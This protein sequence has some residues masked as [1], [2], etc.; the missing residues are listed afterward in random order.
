[1][2]IES[3]APLAVLVLGWAFVSGA[4]QRQEITGPFV[5]V[6]AGALLANDAWGPFPIAVE[7]ASVH[8][9]AE[10]ALA[11]VLFSDAVRID[12]RGLRRHAALPARLLLVG[13]PV[14]MALG[15]GAAL[16]LLSDLPWE[17]ALLVAAA[18]APT[19]AALS[20]QVVGDKRVPGRLRVALNVES[21]LN[22]GMAT[23]V[24]ALAIALAA[25]VLGLGTVERAGIGGALLELGLGLAVGGGFG[26]IGAWGVTVSSR[27]GWADADALRIATFATGVGA[28][29]LATAAGGNAFIAA[30]VGGLVFGLVADRAQCDDQNLSALSELGGELMTLVVWFLFGAALIPLVIEYASLAIVG[31]ALLSLTV[32]R[33]VPVVLSM[34]GSGLPWRDVLFLGWFGP[35]GLAS[36]VFALLTVESLGESEAVS[37]AVAT[38]ATTVACSVVLHGLTAGPAAARYGM[39]D[40]MVVRGRPS[41]LG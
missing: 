1:M 27:R 40:D 20:S 13:L 6:T 19:D 37:V 31:Y 11:L 24:V 18:L 23:P 28:F 21:G 25:T 14:T 4:L 15:F 10:I 8:A 36:V 5:F 38:I 12:L 34:P 3:L 7:T 30:F 2:N 32:V 29:T 39:E 41:R 16:L 35:R 22:D 26:L 9:L 33:I 17:L